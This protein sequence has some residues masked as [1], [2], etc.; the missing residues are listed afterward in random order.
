MQRM[1]NPKV[2]NEHDSNQIILLF[3]TA[4]EERPQL[5]DALALESLMRDEGFH[6]HFA[7]YTGPEVM[8][9]YAPITSL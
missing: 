5:L 1:L 9:D 3:K 8:R 7:K 2:V 6:Y 4:L